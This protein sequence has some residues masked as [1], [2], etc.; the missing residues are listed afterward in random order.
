MCLIARMIS[1]YDLAMRNS[2]DI[3]MP[4]HRYSVPM[5]IVAGFGATGSHYAMTLL[6]VEWLGIRPLTA[7]AI[8]FA[9]GAAV[10]YALNN[11][12]AFRSRGSHVTTLPRFGATLGVLFLFN[13]GFFALLHE[14]LGVQYM[15]AQVATT[16][17]LIIPGY[18]L[19]R[20]WVF[21]AC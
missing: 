7:S 21:R 9:V 10:K 14:I 3:G 12:V 19:S 16:A 20:F 18:T 13:M 2:R 11:F 8:G 17:L 4:A 1:R 5:Y 6:A 15:I